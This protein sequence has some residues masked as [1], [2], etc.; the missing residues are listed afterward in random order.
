MPAAR[1]Q[2]LPAAVVV[3]RSGRSADAQAVQQL[4]QI[5][6]RLL[7]VLLSVSLLTN[8]VLLLRL[9]FP[10]RWEQ[11]ALLFAPPAE[12][13]AVDHLRGEQGPLVIVYVDFECPYCDKL[14]QQLNALQDEAL[15]FRWVVR[16]FASPELKPGSWR[17]AIASEC[18]ARQQRFWEY[19]ASLYGKPDDHSV[20]RLRA[21]ATASGLDPE[22]FADCQQDVSIA[23]T[24]ERDF[25]LARRQQII[26]T[27]TWFVEGRRVV[28]LLDTPQIRT[29]LQENGR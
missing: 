18:A 11:L 12:L 1:R 19:S 28:G 15:P 9:R 17:A 27:P 14:H 29:L 25:A 3:S 2:R 10:H 24:V 21:L 7:L 5:S 6:Q 8:G 20:D 26:A 23:E 4:H 13:R 16:Q 22:A